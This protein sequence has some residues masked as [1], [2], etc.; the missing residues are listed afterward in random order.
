MAMGKQNIWKHFVLM[1][2][3]ATLARA[4][5][6]NHR[7]NLSNAVQLQTIKQWALGD[8]Y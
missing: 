2:P 5:Y 4:N 8:F 1:I 3:Y 7:L 6:A